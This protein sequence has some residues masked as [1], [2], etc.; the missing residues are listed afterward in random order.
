MKF[1]GM[2][3]WY[4]MRG[5]GTVL[6]ALLT[7]STAMGVMSTARFG[8]ALWPRFATQ[9]LHRNVSLLT[10][11]MLTSHVG[12]AIYDEVVDIRWYDA[13]VPRPGAY[14]GYWLWL[15]T[16][17]T[18]VMLAV[19]ITSL[20]RHRLSHRIWRALHVAAYVSWIFGLLHG[21]GIGTDSTAAW[22]MGVTVTS[23]GVVAA[24]AVVRL[25]TLAHERKIAA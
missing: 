20:L 2:M 17:S 25:A 4:I 11:A 15:G 22:E 10:M 5:T 1:D 16:L 24:V 7:L 18:D 12:I 3:Q 19:V 8:S 13:F 9:A 21:I 6:M 23:V 14:H